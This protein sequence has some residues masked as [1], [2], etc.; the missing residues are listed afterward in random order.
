MGSAS[1]TARC[2]GTHWVL[3]PVAA[4]RVHKRTRQT[5]LWSGKQRYLWMRATSLAALINFESRS[6]KFK[7]V[8]DS[9]GTYAVSDSASP[10]EKE[11]SDG[12]V[13]P[14]R[15]SLDASLPTHAIL[16]LPEPKF[17]GQIRSAGREAYFGTTKQSIGKQ[18]SDHIRVLS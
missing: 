14:D 17:P 13:F 5:R 7:V 11:M 6:K 1:G 16:S 18:N 4:E 2:L 8:V 3:A 10:P 15:H 9:R 12:R